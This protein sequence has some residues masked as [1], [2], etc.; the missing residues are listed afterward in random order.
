MSAAPPRIVS[1]RAWFEHGADGP[2]TLSLSAEGQA[3]LNARSTT[4]AN[5]PI[6]GSSRS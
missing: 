6:E 3:P 4:S 5:A 2:T 1:G